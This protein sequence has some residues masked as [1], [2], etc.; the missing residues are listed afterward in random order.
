VIVL[1]VGA[2]NTD[3][4]V[5]Q[6]DA[7]W[8]RN[9][10]VSGNEITRAFMKKFRVTFEEAERLKQEVNQSNQ[11]DRI[12]RVIEGS[13]GDLVAEIKRSLGFY[14]SQNEGA[15]FK[16]VVV[17][18]NTFRLEMLSEFLADRLG[19]PI[20]ALVELE[21]I[22]MDASLSREV[23]LDELQ[24]MSTA[25]GLALQGVGLAKADVNLLP[26]DVQM[27]QLLDSK[28]WA[29]VVVLVLLVLTVIGSYLVKSG[30]IAAYSGLITDIESGVK[31]EEESQKQALALIESLTPLAT[32]LNRF[33]RIGL[34][35]GVVHAAQ[36]QVL[37]LVDR[38]AT[39]P[40]TLLPEASLS[41]ADGG[42]PVRQPLYLESL[43]IEAPG[44]TAANVFAP[45]AGARQLALTVRVPRAG[46][47]RE[48]NRR[49]RSDLRTL[50]I[51]E[52]LARIYGLPADT[53]LFANVEEGNVNDRVDTW[54]FI[55][56]WRMDPA[57]GNPAPLNQMRELRVT[58]SKYLCT[59][60]TLEPRPTPAAAQGGQ[61]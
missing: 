57:T 1:D 49:L 59:L 23:F 41:A 15:N 54:R 45:T 6:G 13:L 39:D 7:L 43:E 60:A 25:M 20:I 16:N 19:Y 9:L 10:R 44:I 38:L 4:V 28:R 32:T 36:A 3:L 37:A 8:M 42:D 46:D 2:E 53:P 21:R 11:A 52:G 61:P 12:M 26:R 48:M 47:F 18:G 56:T 14:K 17:C 51:G 34:H 27:R 58:V 5:Y 31:Q 40:A 22:E 30:R 55:D 33:D 24:G 29:A 35:R 50:T